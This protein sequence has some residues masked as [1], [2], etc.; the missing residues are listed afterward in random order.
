[1]TLVDPAERFGGATWSGASDRLDPAAPPVADAR[2]YVPCTYVCPR[3]SHRVRF[4]AA[5][6]WRHSVTAVTNL[7]AADADAATLAVQGLDL[8]GFQFVDFY[9]PGCALPVR[10]Y[11]G[12]ETGGKRDGFLLK[13]V[14]EGEPRGR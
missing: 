4:H 6:F 13:V 3:C 2:E 8:R 14:V 5:D 11:F 12:I 7:S 1:M 10:V 9:C